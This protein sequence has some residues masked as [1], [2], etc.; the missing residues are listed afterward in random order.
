M[1]RA[2]LNLGFMTKEKALEFKFNKE[3]FIA[4][5]ASSVRDNSFKKSE[6]S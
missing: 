4:R 3:E 1:V 2:A 5:R 6:N